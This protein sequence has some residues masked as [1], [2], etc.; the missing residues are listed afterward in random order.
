M[1]RK[2]VRAMSGAS[3]KPTWR[4]SRDSSWEARSIVWAGVASCERSSAIARAS[5][6]ASGLGPISEST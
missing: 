1:C 2:L 4:L 6:S 5:P 3:T